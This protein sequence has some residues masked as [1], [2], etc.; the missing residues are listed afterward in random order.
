MSTPQLF[1]SPVDR[2]IV[3]EG[4]GITARFEAGVP[5]PLR[6]SMI[7]TAIAQGILKHD[8]NIDLAALT[9]QAVLD[10]D[11]DLADDGIQRAIAELVS[12]GNPDDFS[13]S[14]K[15]HVKS[16]ERVLCRDITAGERD[17]AWAEFE[18]E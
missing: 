16:I 13:K 7:N 11:E 1:V 6:K 5:R 14:G 15:P 12:G 18:A 10:D 9:P 3:L 2:Q 8:P 4:T 17:A